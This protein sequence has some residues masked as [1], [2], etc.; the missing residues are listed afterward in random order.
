MV[1]YIVHHHSDLDKPHLI[2]YQ[3]PQCRVPIKS[4]GLIAP[5]YILLTNKSCDYRVG[6]Y[7]NYGFNLSNHFSIC[8][9]YIFTVIYNLG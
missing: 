1:Y 6:N 8:I 3:S 2:G 9:I 4:T 5:D 7:S